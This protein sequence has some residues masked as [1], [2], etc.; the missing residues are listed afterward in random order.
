[1]NAESIIYTWM[2]KGGSNANFTFSGGKLDMK[3]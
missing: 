2:N 1:M 3:A